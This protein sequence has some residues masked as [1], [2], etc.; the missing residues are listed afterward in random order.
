[1][2]AAKENG[3]AVRWLTDGKVRWRFLKSLFVKR[4]LFGP[5]G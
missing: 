1:M 2:L 5:G 4:D 3:A